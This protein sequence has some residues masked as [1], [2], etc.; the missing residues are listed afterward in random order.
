MGIRI[1][2]AVEL[3][4]A[5]R[6]ALASLVRELAGDGA[7]VRW[8]RP[9]AYHVT[10]RFIGDVEP[11]AVS[12]LVASVAP[13]VAPL[14]PFALQ[15]GP[16]RLFPSVRRPRVVAVPVTPQEPL[17]GLAAAVER[18]VVEAGLPPERRPFRAHL[19]LGRVGVARPRLRLPDSFSAPEFPVADAVLFQSRL[20]SSGARYTP[21]ERIALGGPD[22]PEPGTFQGE[23]EHGEE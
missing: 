1:F 14:A 10:L 13:R 15:A 7:G 16:P 23:H 4:E 3:D 22:S 11:E 6:S 19:T 2:F 8:V 17:D 5:I 20:H 12:G 9:E 21:L 18:G